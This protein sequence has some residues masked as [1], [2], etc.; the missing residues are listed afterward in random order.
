MQETEG[1]GATGSAAVVENVYLLRQSLFRLLRESVCTS[2]Q[3][4]AGCIGAWRG[5][6]FPRA[7]YCLPQ[8]AA[9]R[10]CS[11]LLAIALVALPVAETNSS[12]PPVLTPLQTDLVPLGESI[13]VPQVL[14][15]QFGTV[16]LPTRNYLF[17]APAASAVLP[18]FL[19]HAA[20]NAMP[21]C[22]SLSE[23]TLP[24]LRAPPRR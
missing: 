1:S 8:L 10:L 2:R 19:G 18:I 22:R 11:I 3:R 13:Q 7:A 16:R 20:R 21:P 9:A 12:A 6:T 23:R 14:P 15:I 17:V 24:W 5:N 4:R